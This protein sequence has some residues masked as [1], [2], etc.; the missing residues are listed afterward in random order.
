MRRPVPHR[1]KN[2]GGHRRSKASADSEHAGQRTVSKRVTAKAATKTRTGPRTHR[3]PI[4]I[5]EY[6]G[7]KS[8]SSVGLDFIVSRT[9]A[10]QAYPEYRAFFLALPTSRPGLLPSWPLPIHGPP[11]SSSSLS[12]SSPSPSSQ[13]LPLSPVPV[14]DR[15]PANVLVVLCACRSVGNKL[16]PI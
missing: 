14:R 2:W 3:K 9:Y 4:A 13:V 15:L 10:L 7:L 8:E 16:S 5:S 11:L 1:S 12:S 6:C